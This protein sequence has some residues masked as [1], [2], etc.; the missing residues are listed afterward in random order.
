MVLPH[1]GLKHLLLIA[2]LCA[3][4]PLCAQ[5][6]APSRAEGPEANPQ[7]T[8]DSESMLK[9]MAELEAELAKLRARLDT[10]EAKA[11]DEALRDKNLLVLYGDIGLR[12]HS[13]F[14]SQTETISRPEFRLHLGVFGTAFDVREQRIRY[15]MRLTTFTSDDVGKPAPTLAW[16]PFPGFGAHQLLAVDRFFID[17]TYARTAQLTLGRFPS[18][19]AGGELVFDDDFNFQGACESLRFDRFFGGFSRWIPRLEL[20]VVQGY[21]AQNNIGLPAPVAEAHPVYFGGQMRIE[22]APF[23]SAPKIE[24]GVLSPQVNSELE[25]RLALGLHWYDGE[26][27]IAANIGTGLL[28]KTTN[29]TG[30]D[31]L[32]VSDFFIGEVVAEVIFLRQKRANLRAWFHGVANFHANSTQRS[33]PNRGERNEQGFEAGITWGMPRLTEQW[34]FRI[35]FRYFLVEPDA[36][37]PEFN[38]EAL[39]TNIKGYEFSLHVQA[40]PSVTIFA[41]FMVHERENYELFGFG[42]ASPTDP[43]RAPGQSLRV[44]CGIFLS[45]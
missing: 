7:P 14:E 30:P 10:A 27:A 9:R 13:L 23:E 1:Q 22:F 3:C 4:A 12:Y 32:I 8:F 35:G 38:D 34:D 41:S 21:L 40:F 19:Y 2:A 28:P 6:P 33:G 44:R 17:Y 36:V 15:N 39:N 25:F 20:V 24:G 45:F 42:R 31:G 43:N 18:P 11:E 16:L 29:V 37:I 26:E 5:A